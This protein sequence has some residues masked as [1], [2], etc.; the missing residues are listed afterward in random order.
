MKV[1][2]IVCSALIS[3]AMVGT[4]AEAAQKQRQR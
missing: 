1:A 3:V 2:W 4:R